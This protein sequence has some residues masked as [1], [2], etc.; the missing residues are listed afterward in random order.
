MPGGERAL[1]GWETRRAAGPG[2]RDDPGGPVLGKPAAFY[3]PVAYDLESLPERLRSPAAYLLNAVHWRGACC[4][5]SDADGFVLL[6][7]DYL[8]RFIPRAVW[9]EVRARL[10]DPRA[11]GGPVIEWDRRFE[12]GEK[13][14]GY[15][16]AGGRTPRLAARTGRPGGHRLRH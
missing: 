6:K 2:R 16:L 4:W 9:Q 15:R 1:R 14:F 3:V 13:C 8:T 12:I 11:T 10:T 5:K 7:Y